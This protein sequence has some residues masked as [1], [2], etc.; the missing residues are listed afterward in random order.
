MHE[1]HHRK[2]SATG[3]PTG[4]SSDGLMDWHA[5][6]PAWHTVVARAAA[7][8]TRAGEAAVGPTSKVGRPPRAV[9]AW[10]VDVQL[11]AL[12]AD[13]A[14]RLDWKRAEHSANRNAADCLSR[15]VGNDST[16]RQAGAQ[17]GMH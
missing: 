5:N 13:V 3:P 10:A 15:Y 17:Q 2:A 8:E 11:E 14:Y 16:L 12:A 7:A 6:A 9:A 1:L 4:S